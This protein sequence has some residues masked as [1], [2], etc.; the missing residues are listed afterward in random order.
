[1]CT[2]FDRGMQT[3]IE[4]DGFDDLPELRAELLAF[5]NRYCARMTLSQAREWFEEAFLRVPDG[6]S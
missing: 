4:F 5:V 1:M 2:W 6:W 3:S